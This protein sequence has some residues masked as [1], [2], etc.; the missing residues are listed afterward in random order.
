MPCRDRIGLA[1]QPRATCNLSEKYEDLNWYGIHAKPCIAAKVSAI[2]AVY[3][4]SACSMLRVRT[5]CTGKPRR[6]PEQRL[7][8]RFPPPK[9]RKEK[10]KKKESRANNKLKDEL[11]GFALC[12]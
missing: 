11:Q 8:A 1:I 10:K 2:Q 5:Y 9:K 3:V 7:G 4:P 6:S 12:C